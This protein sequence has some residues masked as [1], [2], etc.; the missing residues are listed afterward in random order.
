MSSGLIDEQVYAKDAP[1][2]SP[3]EVISASTDSSLAQLRR[4]SYADLRRSAK[5]GATPMRPSVKR[6]TSDGSPAPRKRISRACDACNSLRTKCNG[7]F[8][9]N[10]CSGMMFFLETTLSNTCSV[11]HIMHI[12]TR[13]Q[14]AGQGLEKRPS[15]STDMAR[16]LQRWRSVHFPGLSAAACSVVFDRQHTCC[17]QSYPTAN[18]RAPEPSSCSCLSGIPASQYDKRTGTGRSSPARLCVCRQPVWSRGSQQCNPGFG[19]RPA[20]LQPVCQQASRHGI[21]E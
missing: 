8:P 5:S 3:L 15:C 17:Q 16:G 7:N 12:S 4:V 14:E 10:H 6:D 19:L 9:C 1:P 11:Q 18:Q 2:H 20:D 13:T 21:Y